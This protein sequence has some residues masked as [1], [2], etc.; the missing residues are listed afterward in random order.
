[1][2]NN[3]DHYATLQVQR[4][5]SLPEI[6]AN[7]RRLMTEMKNHPDLGGDHE[8]A[9]LINEA[10]RVLSD[11]ASRQG[12]D[13]LCRRIDQGKEG[14]S[15]ESARSLIGSGT[16]VTLQAAPATDANSGP[17]TAARATVRQC[18]LCRAY[19]IQALGPE[20]RCRSCQ[21]PLS[22][23]PELEHVECEEGGRRVTFRVSKSH[24]GTIYP[25]DRPRGLTVSMRDLSISGLSFYSEIPIEPGQTLQFRDSNLDAVISVVSC[26]RCEDSYSIHAR[27]ITVAFHL[28]GGVFV[29]ATG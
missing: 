15:G 12:Y 2:R 9:A 10:Y 8:I 1:M 21:S 7:Y 29:S 6:K 16:A 11:D 14:D 17:A 23:P 27:L 22:R 18:P 4:D 26:R 19:S 5:A 25:P 28:Q 20:V 3:P 13:H 24:C